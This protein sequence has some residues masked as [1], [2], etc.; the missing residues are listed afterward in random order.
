LAAVAGLAGVAAACG[1]GARTTTVT[2][3]DY[4]FENLPAAVKA[5][6]KLSLRNSSTTEI[7][8]MLLAR[9]PDGEQRSAEALAKLPR[10]QLDLVL[11]GS[12]VAVLVRPPGG[13]DLIRALGDGK[14]TEKGRYLVIC[15]IPTG[16]DPAAFLAATRGTR[17]APLPAGG[18]PHFTLGMYGEIRVQ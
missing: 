15:T 16:V 7:H 10:G 1:G 17:D 4:R 9:L 13:A 2:A 8:E 6:T 11:T 12:T 14:L 3:A 5:G 18:P